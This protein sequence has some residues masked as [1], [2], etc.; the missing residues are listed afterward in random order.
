MGAFMIRSK[1]G[2]TGILLLLAVLLA[3]GFF[4]LLYIGEV[5]VPGSFVF[6]GT[7]REAGNHPS[8]GGGA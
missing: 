4:F 2:K 1:T 6:Y 3:A 7:A 5:F 8:W